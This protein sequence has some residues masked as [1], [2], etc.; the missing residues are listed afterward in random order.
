MSIVTDSPSIF[1]PNFPQQPSFR[2]PCTSVDPGDVQAHAATIQRGRVCHGAS[3]A[4]VLFS[5]NPYQCELSC[6]VPEAN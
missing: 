2:R 1:D 3:D 4:R 5:G 6:W